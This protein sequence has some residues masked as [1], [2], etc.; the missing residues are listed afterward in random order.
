MKLFFFF[1]FICMSF[2]Q[3]TGFL[4]HI[5]RVPRAIYIKIYFVFLSCLHIFTKIFF[6]ALPT[7][8]LRSMKTSLQLSVKCFTRKMEIIFK[9]IIWLK[10][11]QGL[12]YKK[13]N[14]SLKVLCSSQKIMCQIRKCH[15]K[16]KKGCN[17]SEIRTLLSEETHQ[18]CD[19][20]T[21]S[22][23]KS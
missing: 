13:I 2:R 15:L 12:W 14:E 20:A 1:Y 3:A 4:L 22:H 8:Y 9:N 6:N 19:S 5:R 16:K 23:I 18:C 11:R 21:F 10:W 17:I 7:V